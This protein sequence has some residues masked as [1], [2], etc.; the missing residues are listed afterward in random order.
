MYTCIYI[1][2]HVQRLCTCVSLH[3]CMCICICVCVYVYMNAY[4]NIFKDKMNSPNIRRRVPLQTHTATHRNTLHH[5]A[6]H[7]NSLPHTATHFNT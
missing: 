5:I 2:M 4:T 3:L 6:T 7:C 1:N